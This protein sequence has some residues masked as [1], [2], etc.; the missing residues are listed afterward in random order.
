MPQIETEHPTTGPSMTNNDIIRRIRYTFDFNDDKMMKIF[1]LAEAPTTREDISAWLKKDEDPDF[2]SMHDKKLALFLNGLI[3]LNRGKK[4]G[5]MPKAEKNLNNNQVLMKL[6]I[7][8]NF[9]AEDMLDV[10]E[11]ADFS[12]GKHELSAFFRKTDHKHYRACKDQVLRN[13][14]I[15]LQEKFRPIHSDDTIESTDAKKSDDTT[16]STDTKKSDNTTKSTDTK[17]SDNTTESTDTKKSD[18]AIK[19]SRPKKGPGSIGKFTRVKK[20]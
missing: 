12:L 2:K 14:L 20:D 17:K 10:L 4:D 1:N 3:V 9:K 5:P 13:F 7:A 16:E 18:D 15:G 6:R 8:L 11:L 19:T